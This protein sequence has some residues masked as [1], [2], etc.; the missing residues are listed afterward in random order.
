MTCKKHQ[1]IWEKNDKMGCPVC[2]GMKLERKRIIKLVKGSIRECE[3][4]SVGMVYCRHN[5]TQIDL[6][7]LIKGE[8]NAD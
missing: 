1:F 6:I 7:A 4:G 2:H 5:W 3:C 8:N